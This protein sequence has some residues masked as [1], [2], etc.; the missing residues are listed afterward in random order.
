MMG[1]ADR[2]GKLKEGFDADIVVLDKYALDI[3]GKVKLT[4]I[5]G[6]VVYNPD[7]FK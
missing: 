7:I 4:I 3:M 5:D 6:E 2:I 1:C